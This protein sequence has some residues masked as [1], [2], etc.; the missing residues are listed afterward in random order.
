MKLFMT[1]ILFAFG[2]VAH[3]AQDAEKIFETN[4]AKYKLEK[5]SVGEDAT[6]GYDY[7]VYS[8]KNKIVKIREV[9][10][11]ASY[12]TY[13][14]E[15]YFFKDGKLAAVL[16][17]TFPSKLYK[18]AKNG[19]NIPLRLLEKLYL[20]DSKMTRW[21]ENG[22]EVPSTDARWAATEKDI[23]ENAGYKLESYQDFKS[24]N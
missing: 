4:K 1:V 24:G 17:Y 22:K 23:L 5:Y 15:D 16:K 7:L 14:V 13:R 6:S 8:D 3:F 10:S 20:T 12:T 21:I 18:S 9:W 19:T 11:S 2:C